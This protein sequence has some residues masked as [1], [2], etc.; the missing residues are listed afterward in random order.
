MLAIEC[1]LP[2]SI[3]AACTNAAIEEDL[4]GG[5]P[6]IAV[7]YDEI[8]AHVGGRAA[9]SLANLLVDQSRSNQVIAI[10]HSPSVAAAADMH[11]VIQRGAKTANGGSTTPVTARVV[12]ER[13][14]RQE[15]ARMASGDLAVEEAEVFADALIRDGI[16]R[17]NAG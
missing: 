9:V 15:L 4:W 16:R 17:R 12:D 7:I 14:R 5:L 8:D 2:G 13:E 11:V 3:G 10:T 1:A 6:P